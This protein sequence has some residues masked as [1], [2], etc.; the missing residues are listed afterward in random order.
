VEPF[1]TGCKLLGPLVEP[2]LVFQSTMPF[3]NPRDCRGI[4][5]ALASIPIPKVD[6][7]LELFGTFVCPLFTLP[8]CLRL[9]LDKLGS[10][11][12]IALGSDGRQRHRRLLFASPS[13]SLGYCRYGGVVVIVLAGISPIMHGL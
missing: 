8:F 11:H 2:P 9:H 10:A 5:I 12:K 3:R 1:G 4:I 6:H 7:V 13:M